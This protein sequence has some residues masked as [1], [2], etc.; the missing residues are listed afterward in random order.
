MHKHECLVCE[1][2]LLGGEILQVVTVCQK[3]N[4]CFTNNVGKAAKR[5]NNLHDKQ[6]SN[7]EP[8]MFDRLA[9]A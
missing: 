1:K 4:K 6:I 2:K 9:R 5:L 3:Q 7:I 8:T